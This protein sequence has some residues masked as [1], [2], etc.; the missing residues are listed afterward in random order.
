[1]WGVAHD[2]THSRADWYSILGQEARTLLEPNHEPH[3]YHTALVKV[4]AVAI[5]ALEAGRFPSPGGD[6]AS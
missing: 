4:A 6:A 1:M 5:A 2:R 3:E